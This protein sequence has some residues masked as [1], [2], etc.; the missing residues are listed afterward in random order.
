[1]G[2]AMHLGCLEKTDVV[3]GPFV[4][5]ERVDDLVD[6]RGAEHAGL[7]RNDHEET[8]A[9]MQQDPGG[10]SPPSGRD[11]R[12]RTHAEGGDRFFAVERKPAL[13]QQRLY[14]GLEFHFC[15][16]CMKRDD[17]RRFSRTKCKS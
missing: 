4:L 15:T 10:L 5:H 7:R 6:G 1:M 16:P 9:R 2:G 11:H 3:A 12:I 17:F 13:R 8:P 14:K